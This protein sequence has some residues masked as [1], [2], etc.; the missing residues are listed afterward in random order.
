MLLCKGPWYTQTKKQYRSSLDIS[1]QLIFQHCP[2]ASL[3]NA[4]GNAIEN[5][6]DNILENAIE[7]ALG[8]ALEHHYSVQ[9]FLF[10]FFQ[11]FFPMPPGRS[12]DNDLIFLMSMEF[13]QIF[14]VQRAAPVRI[15]RCT[16]YNLQRPKRQIHRP[17][18]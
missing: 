16:T 2:A 8:N 13:F 10:K 15:G 5:A 14:K 17:L 3:G 7:N 4:L 11:A 1:E 18:G 6:L 12:F 9:K